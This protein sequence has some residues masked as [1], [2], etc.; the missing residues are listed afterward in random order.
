MPLY[1]YQAFD[2]AGK[3][4]KGTVEALSESEAK[5][6][7]R[8]QGLMIASLG[9]S[10]GAK[11]ARLSGEQLVTFTALLAQL[12]DAGL[13]LHDSLIALEEQYRG[14]KFHAVI[15]S[16]ADQIKNGKGL[17]EA[18]QQHSRS[19]DKLYCAMVAAGETSG[20]LSMVLNRLA[21]Y[22][23][24]DQKLRRQ[25]GTAMLYPSVLACFAV[26]VTG[27]LL[28]FVV[29]S[30]ESVFE[31]R[32]LNGYTQFILGISHLAQKHWWWMLPS[33]VGAIAYSII[34]LRRPAG[35][36]WLQKM[37]LKVPMLS[38]LAVQ[39][40]VARLCRTLSTMLSGGVSMIESLQVG[41]GVM[42][43]VV[44]EA[45]IAHVEARVIEGSSLSKELDRAPHFPSMVARM[46]AVGEESGTA[47]Q[48]FNKIADIYEGQ[49]DKTLQRVMALAQPVILIVMGLIIGSILL[50]IL[51]PLTDVSALGGG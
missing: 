22:L 51:L 47:P 11:E 6:R 50:A 29:P 1:D 41:R 33:L 38:T 20:A 5:G 32:E 45:E 13:P 34:K 9:V 15:T 48:M 25:I 16:L 27:L 19:F 44:L 43:N 35:Q 49:L 36:E 26:I 12:V 40:A 42:K 21:A 37:V 18:M 7:L 23:E 8:E 24:K 2:K 30:I 31:G 3:K 4:K 14:E 28:F 46:V 39:A 17:S 10:S